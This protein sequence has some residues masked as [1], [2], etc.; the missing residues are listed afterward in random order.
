MSIFEIHMITDIIA[1]TEFYNESSYKDA[2]TLHIVGISR[3]IS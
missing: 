2:F 3:H 1:E